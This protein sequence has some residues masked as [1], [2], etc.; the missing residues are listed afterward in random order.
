MKNNSNRTAGV[1]VTFDPGAPGYPDRSTCTVRDDNLD[2]NIYLVLIRKYM[3][4]LDHQPL[5]GKR[6]RFSRSWGSQGLLAEE[7]ELE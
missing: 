1:I 7:I 3:W 6:I 4:L 5:V 2:N